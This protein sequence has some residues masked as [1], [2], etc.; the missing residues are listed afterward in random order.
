MAQRSA[1]KPAL[2]FDKVATRLV[3]CV[4]DAVRDAVPSGKRVIFAVTAPIRLPSKT[5]A[6]LERRILEAIA[7]SAA[8]VET[9]LH[10]NEIR[11]WIVAA[12]AGKPRVS[13]LVHNPGP[14]ADDL[15]ATALSRH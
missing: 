11:I 6:D 1:G 14:T 4:S 7:T 8:R 15:L 12:A 3:D 10:G 13:G 9:T 2:R 5:A